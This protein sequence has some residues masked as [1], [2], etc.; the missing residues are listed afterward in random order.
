MNL[1]EIK[2]IINSGMDDTGMKRMIILSLSQ[3]KNVIP[4]LMDIL[5]D[6]RS[7]SKELVTDLNAELSR[8]LVVLDSPEL[9]FTANVIAN[10][11]WVA[12]E[13]KKFYKKYEGFI[14]CC[15]NIKD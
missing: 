10:P 8:A 3:D 4:D 13:I 11:K 9:S 1:K 15:F 14:G 6:E 7:Q 12:G 5:A 2:T